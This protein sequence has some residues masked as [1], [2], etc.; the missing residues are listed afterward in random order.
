MRCRGLGP[1]P[2]AGGLVGG[3][4]AWQSGGG[5]KRGRKAEDRGREWGV[6]K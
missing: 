6:V 5:Q 4:A 2:N 1:R 3:L